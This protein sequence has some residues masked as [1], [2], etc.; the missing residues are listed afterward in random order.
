ADRNRGVDP[1]CRIP[2]GHTVS[3]AE[4]ERIAPGLA[5]GRASGGALWYD[6]LAGDTERLVLELVLDADAAGAAVA[7]RLRALGLLR[8]G[9]RVEGVSARDEI[10]G[11]DLEIRARVTIN[12]AGPWLGELQQPLSGGAATAPKLAKAMN[13]VVG[14]RIFGDVAVG[15]EGGGPQK[16]LF[17]FV[18]WRGGTMIGTQYVEHD[19]PPGSCAVTAA[20][21][22]GMTAAVNRIHP[23]AG[24]A[25]ADVRFAHVGLLPLDPCADVSAAAEAR[26]LPR[27]RVIDAA[28]ELGAEGLIAVLGIKYTTGMTV[29][30]RAID[31]ACR[32]LGRAAGSV[33][34]A[35]RDQPQRAAPA[36]AGVDAEA[37][38]RIDPRQPTTVADVRRAV[39]EE[40]ALALTDIV[41]R[42][43]PLGTF[44]N[45]GRD[46]LEA[47]ALAA[48]DELEWDAPRRAREIAL[49]EAE[50]A[51]LLGGR[52]S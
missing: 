46:V 37:T 27:P 1:A 4:L 34:Q 33:S 15:V 9:G 2:R 42:R 38:R 13:I 41:L 11:G 31:L 35:R 24:L 19:G 21:L 16:R 29:A 45:P 49:M 12:A 51:R 6:A 18:P 26:L 25:A 7:N 52:T 22:E 20:D 40:M 48:G 30:A 28:R 50:Y 36:A 39:R 43:T 8:R 17:F 23:G 10:G 47:C 14:R 44:G 5:L 3:R 32:K